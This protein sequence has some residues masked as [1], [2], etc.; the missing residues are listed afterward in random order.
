MSTSEFSNSPRTKIIPI[1]SSRLGDDTHWSINVEKTCTWVNTAWEG[2]NLIGGVK[3]RRVD[4]RNH[5]KQLVKNCFK[6]F[7]KR[8]WVINIAMFFSHIR[9]YAAVWSSYEH[10]NNLKTLSK[11]LMR[12]GSQC[13]MDT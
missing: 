1:M 4:R 2:K 3:H 13:T 9:H 8:H 12:I 7:Q 10:I 6:L 11:F 5:L